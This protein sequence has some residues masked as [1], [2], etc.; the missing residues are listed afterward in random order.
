[1]KLKINRGKLDIKTS[2]RTAKK[3]ICLFHFLLK[4]YVLL[5]THAASF[6]LFLKF[7]FSN[8]L[9]LPILDKKLAKESDFIFSNFSMKVL[10]KTVKNLPFNLYVK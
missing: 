8:L 2:P 9:T 5:K 6:D 4:N 10:N 3:A 7:L 1:V